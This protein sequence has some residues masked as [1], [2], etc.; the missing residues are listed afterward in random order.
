MVAKSIETLLPPFLKNNVKSIENS[1][2][3]NL[4]EN[5]EN[6]INYALLLAL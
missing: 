1:G 2:Y 6:I 5:S 4:T 3:I